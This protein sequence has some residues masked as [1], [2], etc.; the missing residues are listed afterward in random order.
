MP[1]ANIDLDELKLNT[2]ERIAILNKRKKTKPELVDLAFEIAIKTIENMD[3]E[4]FE[5]VIGLK[6]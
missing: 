4:S 1:K 3:S 2:I 5:D 6:K